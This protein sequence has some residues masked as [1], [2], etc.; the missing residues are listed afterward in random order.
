M[1]NNEVKVQ[2]LNS[3]TYPGLNLQERP[4]NL[5]KMDQRQLLGFLSLEC[6]VS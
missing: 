6:H 3:N 1:F 5:K 4:G 2:L